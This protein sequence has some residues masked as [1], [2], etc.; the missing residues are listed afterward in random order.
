MGRIACNRVNT[1]DA[2]A[3]KISDFFVEKLNFH[4]VDPGKGL[5]TYEDITKKLYMSD[6]EGIFSDEDEE[7]WDSEEEM[8]EQQKLF[9][10]FLQKKAEEE[11]DF[12]ID[13]E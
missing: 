11:K 10:E 1:S 3:G 2:I 5:L 13:Y 12:I 6:D 7:G 9:Y 4:R 8:D